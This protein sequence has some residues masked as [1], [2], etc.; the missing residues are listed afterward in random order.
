MVESEIENQ[1]NKIFNSVVHDSMLSFK[2]VQNV[3]DA[4]NWWVWLLSVKL[5][6]YSHTNHKP[7]KAKFLSKLST[8]YLYVKRPSTQSLLCQFR[9]LKILLLNGIALM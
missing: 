6:K 1:D 3:N 4:K 5:L 8:I 9:L 7:R 2:T